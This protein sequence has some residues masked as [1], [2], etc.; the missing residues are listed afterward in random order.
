MMTTVLDGCWQRWDDNPHNDVAQ[1][2]RAWFK[3]LNQAVFSGLEKNL[4]GRVK[5]YPVST[6]AFLYAAPGNEQ[7][8]ACVNTYRVLLSGTSFTEQVD[9]AIGQLDALASRDG[10]AVFYRLLAPECKIDLDH[11]PNRRHLSVRM[12]TLPTGCLPVE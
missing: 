12:R 5:V 11:K 9:S 7:H 2:E 1:E 3:E 10:A 6:P 4:A 8:A